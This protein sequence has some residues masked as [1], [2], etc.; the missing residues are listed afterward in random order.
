VNQTVIDP[1]AT[2]VAR[3]EE[4]G[5]VVHRLEAWPEVL[6]L[7]KSL[8]TGNALIGPRALEPHRELA[9]LLGRGALLAPADPVSVADASLGVVGGEQAIAETGSVLVDDSRLEDRLVSMLS[10]VLVQ[11]ITSDRLVPS[12]DQAATWLRTRMRTPPGYCVLMSGPSR[13]GS[14][15]PRRRH[16]EDLGRMTLGPV[17]PVALSGLG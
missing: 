4:A 6:D 2:F 8:G 17:R 1:A 7:L 16:V 15:F 14:V 11:V 9:P 13:R 12:L 5:A 10:H 3:A